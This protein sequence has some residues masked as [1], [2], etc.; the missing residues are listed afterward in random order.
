MPTKSSC[1]A[2]IAVRVK[3]VKCVGFFNDGERILPGSEEMITL[4]WDGATGIICVFNQFLTSLCRV[5]LLY[6]ERE[7]QGY[8]IEYSWS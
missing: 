8:L 4:V 7:M 6:C 3:P 5:A 2:G 1:G